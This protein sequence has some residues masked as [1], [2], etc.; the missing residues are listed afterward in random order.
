MDQNQTATGALYAVPTL[1]RVED[2]AAG[3]VSAA[4]VL[5]L[6]LEH[7]DVFVPTMAVPGDAGACFVAQ[8]GDPGMIVASGMQ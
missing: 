4:L 1:C 8:Q 3:G 6:A 7:I 5:R 2:I